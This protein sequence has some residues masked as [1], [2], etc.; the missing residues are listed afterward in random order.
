MR[1]SKR[2]REKKKKLAEVC[3]IET[4]AGLFAII[5]SHPNITRQD[6]NQR[7][8][9]KGSIARQENEMFRGATS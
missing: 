6:H 9:R 2:E 4:N 1:K 7:A 8:G 5:G 3:S